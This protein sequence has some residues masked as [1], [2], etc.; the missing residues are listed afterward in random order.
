M[1][2]SDQYV[3]CIADVNNAEDPRIETTGVDDEPVELLIT[4]GVGVATHACDGL[5]DSADE[6]TITRWLLSH[7]S[8]VDAVG[9]SFGTPVP[10]VEQW[11]STHRDRI[12]DTLERLSGH[13]EY[14]ITLLWNQEA[15]TTRVAN[16]DE[17]LQQLA[18][19]QE[20][21]TEG[22]EYM[23][24]RQREQRLRELEQSR[25]AELAATLADTVDSVVAES[26]EFDATDIRGRE[27]DEKQDR[28]TQLAVLA[29]ETA[30]EKL[31]N[32]LDE[33]ATIDG[34][35]VRFTGPWPPYAFTPEF[36]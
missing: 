33:I 30:E 28:V 9:D 19:R 7:Q 31:G 35:T 25:R 23:L 14:R 36:E 4:D 1:S 2:V 12:D 26:T 20:A 8:V 15:F 27:R 21:A 13:W 34:V 24:E 11:V 3:Y 16:E 5:Y 32:E 18:R 29:H 6:E 17:K 22:T 10:I